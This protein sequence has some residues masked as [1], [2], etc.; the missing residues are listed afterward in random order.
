VILYLNIITL[1]MEITMSDGVGDTVMDM[2][3]LETED[4]GK[5]RRRGVGDGIAKGVVR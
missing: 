1:I 3:K 2:G 5:G 4:D